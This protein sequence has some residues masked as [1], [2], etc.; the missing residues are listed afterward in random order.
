[1]EGQATGGTHLNKSAKYKAQQRGPILL[2][3]K[4]VVE[5]KGVTGCAD[6]GDFANGGNLPK[7][8][9]LREKKVAVLQN[10]FEF[11]IR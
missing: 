11:K 1:V 6:S 10:L 5:T 7:T 4:K 3:L 9:Y 2:L 8:V